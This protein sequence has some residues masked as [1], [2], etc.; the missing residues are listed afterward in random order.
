[1]CSFLYVLIRIRVFLFLYEFAGI[2][3]ADAPDLQRSLCFVVPGPHDKLSVILLTSGA[4]KRE[5]GE[6]TAVYYCCNISDNG[7]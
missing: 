5:V 1:M 6:G 3:L 4:R 2:C 7:H